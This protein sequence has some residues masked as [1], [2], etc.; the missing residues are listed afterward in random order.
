MTYL[1]KSSPGASLFFLPLDFD[2][3]ML[4]NQYT[5]QKG[6]R[7]GKREGSGRPVLPD[8]QKTKRRS[9]YLTE[10][11]WDHCFRLFNA[12]SI[13]ASEYIRLLVDQDMKKHGK[14]GFPEVEP[15][16]LRYVEPGPQISKK[17]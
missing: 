1:V 14:G 10:S 13:E 7:G 17:E 11:Q 9:V 6:T 8:D 2:K 15:S 16:E 3:M 4:Y 12:Q 5:M